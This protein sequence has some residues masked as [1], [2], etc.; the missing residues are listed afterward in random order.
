M[1]DYFG[2]KNNI[3]Y[4]ILYLKM[5]HIISL[6]LSSNNFYNIPDFIIIF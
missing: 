5:Q 4:I 1:R 2:A 6:F 3:T